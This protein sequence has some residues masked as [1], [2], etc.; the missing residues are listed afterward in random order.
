MR[1]RCGTITRWEC[2]HNVLK[3]RL[4]LLCPVYFFFFFFHKSVF[5][6]PHL[7]R[8]TRCIYETGRLLCIFRGWVGGILKSQN[9]KVPG[10]RN[11]MLLSLLKTPVLK[12]TF[13]AQLLKTICSL[14]CSLQGEEKHSW[15][16][17]N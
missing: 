10:N 16:H 13:P 5:F 14:H 12:S 9:K 1:H 4:V 17:R 3:K 15:H 11:L 8:S 2:I 7:L 6:F